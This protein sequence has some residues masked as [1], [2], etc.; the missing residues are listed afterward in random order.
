MFRI[1][2]LW[3]RERVGAAVATPWL[4]FVAFVLLVYPFANVLHFA[5]PLPNL[6]GK[7]AWA[8]LPI[9]A[10]ALIFLFHIQPWSLKDWR[11]FCLVL[12]AALALAL[13]AWARMPL[14]GE[15]LELAH[16]RFAATGVVFL[17]GADGLVSR[18]YLKPMASIL[19]MAGM[20]VAIV[21][22]VNLNFF[23]NVRLMTPEEG[24]GVGLTF[25]VTINDKYWRTRNMLLNASIAGNLMVCS[26]FV[27]VA[28]F[29]KIQSLQVWF[30]WIGFWLVLEFMA[31]SIS[32]QGSRYP[33]GMA[34]VL[35]LY[36]MVKMGGRRSWG[37]MGVAFLILVGLNLGVDYLLKDSVDGVN[38]AAARPILRFSEGG[39]G[40]MEKAALGLNML[41]ATP[42]SLIFGVS[43][44]EAGTTQSA[45]G[46]V[47]SD[48]SYIEVMLAVGVPAGLFFFFAW[49]KLLSRYARGRLQGLYFA[50]FVGNLLLTNSILWDPWL[51]LFLFTVPVIA[52]LSMS[53]EVRGLTGCMNKAW[54][55][56]K[57]VKI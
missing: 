33:M 4:L 25:N 35:I 8:I 13:V 45:N 28:L 30:G 14:Y 19:I 18:G 16:L 53:E 40:R 1:L 3:L 57:W 20:L 52:G 49:A 36:A 29:C 51:C 47:F 6:F 24:G 5:L 15:P 38:A 2:N 31:Y 46:V 7:S 37:S 23:P 21:V 44:H 39:G 55:P 17:G 34:L 10:L 27:L 56:R 12:M 54:V 32:L 9:V 50:Y 26:M 22:Y 41:T 42:H 48:N 11:Q 43:A